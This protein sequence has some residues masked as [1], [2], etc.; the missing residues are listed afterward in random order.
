MAAGGEYEGGG[1][2]LLE[3]KGF[4][5]VAGCADRLLVIAYWKTK[6]RGTHRDDV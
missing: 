2:E 5:T 3:A 6:A 4:A 1:S